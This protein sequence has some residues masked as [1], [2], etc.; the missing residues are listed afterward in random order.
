VVL[1][2][3]GGLQFFSGPLPQILKHISDSSA[4]AQSIRTLLKQIGLRGE[5]CE[6][7]QMSEANALGCRPRGE[8]SQWSSNSLLTSRIVPA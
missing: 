3:G 2:W 4:Q 7:V 5:I 1:G 8:S 6:H